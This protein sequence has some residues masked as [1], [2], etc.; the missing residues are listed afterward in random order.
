MNTEQY[1]ECLGKRIKALR[2]QKGLSQQALASRMETK[3]PQ[4]VKI[5]R[6]KTNVTIGMLGKIAVELDISIKE[7]VI[8]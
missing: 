7:L 8:V 6:G 4:I 2:K 3:H 5:E 1:L